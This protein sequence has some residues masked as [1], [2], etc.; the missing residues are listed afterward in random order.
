V[1]GSLPEGAVVAD[2]QSAQL[3]DVDGDGDQRAG[4]APSPS[5]A[6][7]ALR[8]GPAGGWS[9][10]VTS[11]LLATSASILMLGASVALLSAL[12]AAF[13]SR[14]AYVLLLT[15][16]VPSLVLMLLSVRSLAIDLSQL[17]EPFGSPC[18]AHALWLLR[19]SPMTS[20]GF[21]RALVL[22]VGAA[23]LARTL[24]NGSLISS[25]LAIVALA[26]AA[27]AAV[28][29]W[30]VCQM[31]C[32]SLDGEHEGALA[33]LTCKHNSDAREEELRRRCQSAGCTDMQATEAC[34][35]MDVDRDG[36]ISEED[37]VSFY[38]GSERFQRRNPDSLE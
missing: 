31:L 5:L 6:F 3:N 17:R 16:G 24:E 28:V 29:S 35:S 26:L 9:G 22:L 10:H 1:L 15:Q 30:P 34:I 14:G 13:G 19:A 11:A 2:S 23:M 8:E 38:G 4:H 25:A 33:L 27:A 20:L 21:V 18:R 36:S 7:E 37:V 12:F 32:W